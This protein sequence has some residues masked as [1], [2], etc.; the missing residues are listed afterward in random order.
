MSR[1]TLALLL[2]ASCL[3]AQHSLAQN[4]ADARRAEKILADSIEAMGGKERVKQIESCRTVA[5]MTVM[6]QSLDIEGFWSKNGGRVLLMKTPLG[7]MEAGSDGSIGWQ[8][9]PA[10]VQIISDE[11]RDGIENQASFHM[12]MLTMPERL[13]HEFATFEARGEAEFEGQPCWKIFFEDKDD[14]K[15]QGHLFFSKESSL[16]VGIEQKRTGPQGREEVTKVLFLDW[17]PVG[18]LKLFHK[19]AMSS[20]TPGSSAEIIFETIEFNKVDP[21]VFAVPEEVKAKAKAASEA[22]AKKLEDFT[23]EQQKQIREMLAG[24]EQVNDPAMLDQTI[25]SLEQAIAYMPE[26]EA[27]M[28]RYVVAQLKAKV[29]KIKGG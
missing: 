18:D 24:L 15:D 5:R 6:G 11:Q 29:K 10:G 8:K 22:E 12:P 7:A 3:L 2:A 4:E 17:K 28:Y 19:M 20:A 16:P 23:P 21:A 13:H 25:R 9:T 26:D 14:A 27:D 1:R